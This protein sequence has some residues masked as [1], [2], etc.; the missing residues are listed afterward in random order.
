L[1][2]WLASYGI[3][4]LQPTSQPTNQP[5]QTTKKEEAMSA[6]KFIL[7]NEIETDHLSW[8]T[9][10]WV[11]RPATTGADELVVIEV[12]LAQGQGHNFHKHPDQEEVI[13]V[14]AGQVEQWLEGN[15]Q[16]LGPGDSV[17]IQKNIVHASFN[18]FAEPA[19]LI[20]ILAPCVTE[21][22]YV[23]VEVGDQ[24]P[25]KDLR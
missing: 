1:V 11:S 18:T 23:T 20:A 3:G 16:A 15:K 9:M 7:N 17:F 13:Y 24:A 6:G 19:K 4:E 5:T 22:G 12:N 21:A 14:V 25:W 10:G 8:G 2:G